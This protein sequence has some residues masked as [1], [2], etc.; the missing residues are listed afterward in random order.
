[1]LPAEDNPF[2]SEDLDD[3][4][5]EYGP[6]KRL[7]MENGSAVASGKS[8]QARS[9]TRK[10]K[11]TKGKSSAAIIPGPSPPPQDFTASHPFVLV[12]RE[13]ELVSRL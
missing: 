1:M 3:S 8:N 4:L 7:R 9:I 6:K 13:F 11:G 5:S 2:D 10:N 12:E